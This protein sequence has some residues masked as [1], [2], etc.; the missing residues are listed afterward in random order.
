[1]TE[2]VLV[3]VAYEGALTGTSAGASTEA[4]AVSAAVIVDRSI[5]HLV[6]CSYFFRVSSGKFLHTYVGL[7]VGVL[8]TDLN[9]KYYPYNQC[10]NFLCDV[11]GAHD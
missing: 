10:R 8:L 5:G 1:M 4:V 9:K 7:Y 11:S 2:T 3:A 6:R